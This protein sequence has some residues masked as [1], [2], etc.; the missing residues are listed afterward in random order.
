MH[1]YGESHQVGDKHY[2][3]CRVRLVSLLLPLQHKPHHKGCKHRR[4]GIYLT[5]HSREPEG[6]GEGVGQCSHSTCS[7]DC[8]LVALAHCATCG[9][10]DAACKVGDCPE[11]EQN[12]EGTRQAV[13]TIYHMRHI[14]G[15]WREHSSDACHQH[16]EGCSRWVS[17]LQ[18]VRC[19]DELGAVPKARRRLHRE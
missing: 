18:L 2:P 17:H 12:T 1:T 13:H 16:K 15:V 19:C 6:V 4:E 9:G 14:I 8:N 10:E 7:Q 3:A 5:L 11:E